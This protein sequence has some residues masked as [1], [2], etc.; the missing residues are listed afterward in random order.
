MFDRIVRAIR[1]DPT[2]YRQVADDKQYTKEAFIIVLIVSLF[3]AV[4]AAIGAAMAD[5]NALLAFMTSL[6]STILFGW[7]L[8]AVIAYFL[9]TMLGGKSGVTEMARTLG[10]ANAPGLLGVF[11]FI[12]C[13]G[14]MIALAGLLL[15]LV[16][17]VI[18][19]RESMEFNTTSALI[20][21]SAGFV[22][23]IVVRLVIGFV[24]GGMGA[25]GL[26]IPG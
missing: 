13:V 5:A 14:W 26:A 2:L 16:A 15:S 8:W 4:G 19:I 10:Y 11:T 24:L 6:L 7:L 17:G 21:A 25:A 1:L 3:S 23:Y 20:T 12:P 9:G 22:A 18:A